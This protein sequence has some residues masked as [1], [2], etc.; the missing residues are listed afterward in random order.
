MKG[1]EAGIRLVTGVPE[2]GGDRAASAR[3]QGSPQQ[4]QGF[5]PGGGGKHTLERFEQGYNGGGARHEGSP[6]QDD[7]A[8]A[9]AS[10]LPGASCR[11]SSFKNVQSRADTVSDWV[12][13]DA[14]YHPEGQWT[15]LTWPKP[16][17]TNMTAEIRFIACARP[18][19]GAH[20]RQRTPMVTTLTG[21]PAGASCHAPRVPE[22][23][24]AT[25]TRSHQCAGSTG[26]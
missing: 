10:V 19:L 14:P 22:Y 25:R 5:L 18:S 23:G 2:G 13:V 1:A 24:S 21:Q 4:G 8:L 26:R 16:P 6:G 3:Q 9:T 7:S 15:R 20:R 17:T 11:V 12:V